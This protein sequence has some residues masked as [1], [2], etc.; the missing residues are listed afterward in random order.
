M[1]VGLLTSRGVIL[2]R[3]TSVP[4]D[5][6][7]A[8]RVSS[9]DSKTF[10]Q[11]FSFPFFRMVLSNVIPPTFFQ[12]TS[13]FSNVI[14]SPPCLNFI[15]SPPYLNFILSPPCL[16]FILSPPCLNFILSP[17]CL[18]FILS[19]PCL[20]FILSPPCLNFILSPPYLNFILSPPCLNTRD[21]SLS[22]P[23]SCC[24]HNYYSINAKWLLEGPTRVGL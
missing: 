3:S 21:L 13:N 19:P 22:P 6:G 23:C 7:R 8:M 11:L 14:L 10:L 1:I 9:T 20:N 24:Q 17:P 5:R 15:L 18:H 12:I 16:N 2:Y 4:C